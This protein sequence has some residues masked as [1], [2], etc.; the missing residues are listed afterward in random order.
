MA[1]FHRPNGRYARLTPKGRGIAV[2][3]HIQNRTSYREPRYSGT[4]N[5]QRNVIRRLDAEIAI[6]LAPQQVLVLEETGWESR[7]V[8]MASRFDPR[9]LRRYGV[10]C[11]AC[12]LLASGAQAAKAHRNELAVEIVSEQAA[13]APDGQSMSF[14]I[15]TTCDRKWTVLSARVSVVQTHASGE[16]SFTPTCARISY[17]V[18][19][20]V[21][22]LDGPFQTGEA[23]V[24]A[25]LIVQQSNTREARASASLR[26]RPSVSVLVADEAVLDGGGEAIRIDVTTTCPQTSIGRGG[27]I[28]VYDGQ[29]AGTGFFAPTP[30]DG[31]PHTS[32][33]RVATSGG[34]FR[35]GSAEAF[36][37]ASVEE[38][39][40]SFPGT[41]VRTIQIR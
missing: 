40:D 30:C 28:S 26:V 24:S 25:V 23:K 4:A 38:G 34:L 35:T 37:F 16:A 7:E 33:V 32:S 8:A 3:G 12:V 22:A 2:T 19:V 20:T 36:A 1:I 27:E 13:L 21:P 11:L 5:Q 29:A 17:G 10:V 31:L 9:R 39:G 41:D 6:P 15:T 18:R 14:D